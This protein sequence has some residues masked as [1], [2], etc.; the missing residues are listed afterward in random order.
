MALYNNIVKMKKGQL[1]KII[2]EEHPF[3]GQVVKFA[4]RNVNANS[5]TFKTIGENSGEVCYI[6]DPDDFIFLPY[7]ESILDL[8]DLA[9]DTNDEEWAEELHRK[10]I[11]ECELSEN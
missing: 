4:Y 11:E 10:L 7:E 9:L 8:I 3:Y 2:N 6:K 5:Y 1:C